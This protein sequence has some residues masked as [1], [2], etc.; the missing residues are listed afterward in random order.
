MRHPRPLRPESLLAYFALLWFLC[1]QRHL[2]AWIKSFMRL[3]SVRKALKRIGVKHPQLQV[4]KWLVMFCPAPNTIF[5]PKPKPSASSVVKVWYFLMRLE[6][7]SQP[8]AVCHRERSTTT[9]ISYLHELLLVYAV[10]RHKSLPFGDDLNPHHR[11][12]V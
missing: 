9:C 6:L 1:L 10:N 12:I 3:Q 5:A 11:I 8:V 4:L 7:R 2:I